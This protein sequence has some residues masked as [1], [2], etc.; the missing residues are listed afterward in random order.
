VAAITASIIRGIGRGK[1]LTIF[2]AA[3]S[4]LDCK[5]EMWPGDV[6]LAIDS[7]TRRFGTRL[8]R[9]VSHLV[10]LGAKCSQ[11][12]RRGHGVDSAVGS[13]RPVGHESLSNRF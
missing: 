6:L 9:A 2:G 13:E 5:G 7:L 11:L 12:L 3:T 1:Y 8:E 4:A 10:A